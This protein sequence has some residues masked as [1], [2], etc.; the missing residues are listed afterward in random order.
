MLLLYLLLLLVTTLA[1]SLLFF[2]FLGEDVP[3]RQVCHVVQEEECVILGTIF[4]QMNLQPSILKEIS[5]EL[6]VPVQP[7]ASENFTCEDDVIY[8]EDMLQ[9]IVLAGEINK[10]ELVT[11]EFAIFQYY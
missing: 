9:R 7:I 11:G 10:D 5:D 8:L 1:H 3:I 6:D 4:K 2:N